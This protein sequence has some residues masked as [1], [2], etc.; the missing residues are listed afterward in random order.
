MFV[1]EVCK[2]LDKAKVSYAIVGG[3]AVALHGAARGTFDVD[4]VLK[5]TLKNLQDAEK[6]LKNLGLVSLLPLDSENVFNFRDEYI[7]NR[8]LIAWNF[9]DP[10]DPTKQVDLIINYNLNPSSIKKV[11]THF[12]TLC[13]LSK[14][15][16]IAMKKRSGRPQDLEDVK[17]LESL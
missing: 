12:G 9:Y 13:I 3:Y 2:A 5:W 17:S 15:D 10:S 7:Q 6:A 4:L 14:K 1:K 16:L 11:K 8:N